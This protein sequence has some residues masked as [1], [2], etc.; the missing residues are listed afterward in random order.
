MSRYIEQFRIDDQTYGIEDY[1]DGRP[2]DEHFMGHN[3]KKGKDTRYHLWRNGCGFGRA[4]TLK[5]ARQLVFD[6]AKENLIS[7]RNKA[8]SEFDRADTI[9]DALGNDSARLFRFMKESL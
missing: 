4:T 9:L 2:M 7:K 6:F 3:Y 8:R 5:R 1:Q